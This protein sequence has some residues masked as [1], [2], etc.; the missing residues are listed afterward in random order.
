MSNLHCLLLPLDSMGSKVIIPPF[1][2]VLNKVHTK[3]CVVTFDS[4][5]QALSVHLIILYS[6]RSQLKHPLIDLNAR[7]V[8]TVRTVEGY[9]I[10]PLT[11]IL[12]K[13]LKESTQI[14]TRNSQK[15]RNVTEVQ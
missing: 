2:S 6:N 9:T 14:L 11:K 4:I 15:Y 12:E 5:I 13:F 3:L 8:S 10:P 7:Y 1:F